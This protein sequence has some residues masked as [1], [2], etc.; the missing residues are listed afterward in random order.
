MCRTEGV[1]AD[2]G[3]GLPISSFAACTAAIALVLI[4]PAPSAKASPTVTPSS[5]QP[6]TLVANYPV[7]IE[8]PAVA[9][10]GIFAY[11]AAGFMGELGGISNGFFRYD[12][13]ANTWTPLPSIPTAVGAARGVYAA[14][15]NSFYVFGGFDRTNVLNITQIYNFGTNTWSSGATMP[16]ARFFS[17]L[18]YD[19]TTGKIFVIGGFHSTSSVENTQTWE[20][21]PVL[22]TWNTTRANIPVGMGG[23]ATSIAGQFIYL[24][25]TWNGGAGSNAHY[26]YDIT[27]NTWTAMA[28]AP[29]PVYEAAGAAIGG[30]TYVI[31]GGGN[32]SRPQ[33]PE[34]GAAALV[35]TPGP[36][37][38]YNGT[39]VYDI[40][41][42]TWSTGP[43]LN[44]A[45]SFTAG[46][47]I[48]ARLLVVGG[49]TGNGPFVTDTVEMTQGGGLYSVNTT[50]DTVVVGA[51]A[52]GLAGCS[53]RG[54]I[55]AA[56]SH[57]GD[58]AIEIDL[59]AGSVINLTQALPDI[60]EGVNIS[61]PGASALTVRRN[62][63][64]D[65][66]IFNVETSDT[67]A[68]SGLTISNGRALSGGPDGVGAGIRNATTG[69]INVTN[70]TISGNAANSG[71]GIFTQIGTVNVTNCT[72]SG[73]SGGG[74][75]NGGATV[76]IN[77]STISGNSTSDGGGIFSGS[78]FVTIINSTISSNS[79][80]LTGGGIH[81]ISGLV[82]ITNST[83]S[84]NGAGGGGGI[85]NGDAVVNVRNTIIALNTATT[86]PD[87]SG[88]V[89][90]QGFNLLGNNSGATILSAQLSD[91]IGT[92]GSP[93]D[94]L[95]G[96]LQDNGGP[97][98]TRALLSG[99]PAID[100]GHSSGSATDQRGPGFPRTFDD[101]AITNA[102]GGDGTDIG[103]FELGGALVPITV[104]RKMHGATMFD[105][106][107]PLTGPAGIEC[108]TGG[109]NSDHQV[110]V[111]FPSPVTVA[112]ASVT[113]GTGSVSNFTTSGSQVTVNLTGVANAQ[114]IVLTLVGVNN[115]TSTSNVT[116]P[117]EV[118][119][120]DTTGDR[121]VNAGDA[122]QTR[123]RSGQATEATNFR[124]DVNTDGF[125]NS[126]DTTVVRSRAG[127]FLP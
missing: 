1:R 47:A 50:S 45:R 84:G 63:G 54:A 52:N 41:S 24:V 68:F 80:S 33:S 120:G 100:K 97:T 123:S 105:I 42:N 10:D 126:G 61:G 14:N 113:T 53:L 28:V 51:C 93:I 122:L 81:S 55:Q 58:D 27:G 109:M 110:V 6:W 72:I 95:L 127:T 98:F 12:P 21:D 106:D 96:V 35:R 77:N 49:G 83:I 64:G 16:A 92:P 5:L 67:V 19:S 37:V 73:N 104:S 90:S 89:T 87:V 107:L 4:I 11:S 40:A 48:G 78:G 17:N 65:Y 116:I 7:V 34:T 23:S 119:L 57:L 94:P 85:S 111:S 114:T 71:G 44:V 75:F 13:V 29:V 9:S 102:S 103:A 112:S 115:G 60:T 36:D 30:Q 43:N 82:S 18:A 46:T 22:N 38:A 79:A 117:M 15:T 32:P 31:G 74:I 118:L 26:R 88:A 59:L 101:P 66:R 3:A 76:T 39:Y 121:F 125:L 8:A 25:G 56:N 124:S 69:T 86:G 62:T 91:Q 108:R 99:S 2:N 70:C 20:Y